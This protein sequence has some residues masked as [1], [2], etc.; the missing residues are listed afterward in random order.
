MKPFLYDKP[1]EKNCKIIMAVKDGKALYGT[2]GNIAKEL[3]FHRGTV[4]N[5]VLY[6]NKVE[7]WEFFEAYHRAWI[8][9]TD[10][11]K[12]RY[13]KSAEVWHFI[14]T[15]RKNYVVERITCWNPVAVEWFKNHDIEDVVLV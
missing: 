12:E 6:G 11:K 13:E 9:S 3:Y 4:S 8:V 10:G 2:I 7:G 1:V 5:A 15:T 14:L